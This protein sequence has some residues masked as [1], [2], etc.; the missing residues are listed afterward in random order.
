MPWSLRLCA[1]DA[2]WEILQG[3]SDKGE[4]GYPARRI[5][6]CC[7]QLISI[8]TS[9]PMRLLLLILFSLSVASPCIAGKKTERDLRKASFEFE[10]ALVHKDT[11]K[12]NI[13]LH[14]KLRY[15]HSNGWIET[16]D[17]LK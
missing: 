13:T 17:E 11:E 2:A 12:L 1:N 8:V 7:H 3:K 10:R 14:P 4:S 15:G 5:K 6:S 9:T 16:K